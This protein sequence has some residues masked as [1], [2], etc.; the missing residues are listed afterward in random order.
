M[1]SSS[2][3]DT[4][5]A[6]PPPVILVIEDDDD[7]LGQLAAALRREGYAVRKASTGEAAVQA[8]GEEPLPS[9]ITLD[10]GLPRMSGEE[11]M[12]VKSQYYRWAQI[13]VVVI[14]G[15]THPAGWLRARATLTKPVEWE[16]LLDVVNACCPIVGRGDGG[17]GT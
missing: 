13:P 15:G 1:A 9:L 17:D 4:I 10:L 8:L 11:F 5:P 2:Q 16:Q 14:S 7:L 6:P 3:R 12:A